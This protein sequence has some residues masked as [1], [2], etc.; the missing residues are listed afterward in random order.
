[1]K[2]DL[3]DT[4]DVVLIGYYRGE[5]K[6]AQ[7]GIGALL[8][9]VYDSKK[10]AF[11]TVTKIGTGVTHEQWQSIKIACDAVKTEKAL[12]KYN[13]SKVSP[14]RCIVVSRVSSRGRS[15]RNN[16]EPSTHFGFCTKVSTF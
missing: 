2:S 9:A 15:R 16:K 3:A 4:V 14:T 12:D 5:G 10:D 13:Y 11:L 6:L 8:A 1:M 7:F